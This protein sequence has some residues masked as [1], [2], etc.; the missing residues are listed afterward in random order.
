MR[1]VASKPNTLS[2][3]REQELAEQTGQAA[4]QADKQT[5]KQTDKQTDAA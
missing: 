4:E 1:A 5:G 2:R 3:L